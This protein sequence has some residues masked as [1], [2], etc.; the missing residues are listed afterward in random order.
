MLGG[1]MLVRPSVG[2]NS[3]NISVY[4]LTLRSGKGTK[5]EVN[6]GTQSNPIYT[7]EKY[8]GA[9][10]VYKG[11]N[12]TKMLLKKYINYCSSKRIFDV[13]ID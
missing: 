11:G 10:F 2:S 1:C 9:I 4:G 6:I 7:Y 3:I 5:V 8:G 13:D 12:V